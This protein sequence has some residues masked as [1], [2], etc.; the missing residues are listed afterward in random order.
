MLKEMG[1]SD[2]ADNIKKA[3]FLTL[4]EGRF[5][6]GDLG[7]KGSTTDYTKRVIDHL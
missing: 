6:T 4:K 7:G 2:E 1:Y 3:I 5:T